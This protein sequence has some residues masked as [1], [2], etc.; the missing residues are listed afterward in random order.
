VHLISEGILT[1]RTWAVW[2]RDKIGILMW[3]V[4][5]AFC[6]GSAV[7]NIL[8]VK[9]V[10]CTPRRLPTE[11][12]LTSSPVNKFPISTRFNFVGCFLTGGN[13]SLSI[14]W[15]LL[16]AYDAWM[17]SWLG[18]RS[19]QICELFCIIVCLYCEHRPIFTD[20][21]GGQNALMVTVYRDGIIYYIY[22]LSQ[23]LLSSVVL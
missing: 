7:T 3:T 9:G 6:T 21:Q 16:F 20:H 5:F 13:S 22:L 1:F 2:G 10:I 15:T 12:C 8:A 18:V 19:I 4:F 11:M 23:L 14:T 17:V